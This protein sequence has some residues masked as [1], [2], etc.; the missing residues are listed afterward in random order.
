M[1]KNYFTLGHSD[2]RVSPICLG[3]MNFSLQKSDKIAPWAIDGKA[4]QDIIE[5]YVQHGGNFIDT[6]NFYTN[7]EAEKVVGKYMKDAGNRDD[8]VIA[9]KFT[10]PMKANINYM[11]NGRKN[12]MKSLEDSLERLQTNFI[13]L[14]YVHWW[15]QMSSPEEVMRSLDILVQSGKVGHIGLS[16]VPAWFFSRCQSLAMQHGYERIAAMQLEYNLVERNIEMEYFDMSRYYNT[17]I[18]PWSPIAG[19]FLTGKQTK[20]KLQGRSATGTFPVRS[21]KKWEILDCVKEVAKKIDRTPV[22]VALN[23]ALK[24]PAVSS[25][26]IGASTVEHL[27]ANMKSVEFNIPKDQ[28]KKL[29]DISKPERGAPYSFF[30]KDSFVNKMTYGD[31]LKLQQYPAWHGKDY[32][33]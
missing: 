7:G 6:A 19:G 23:W 8:L 11:G 24:R 21:E 25:I 31:H 12:M 13:D 1:K 4:P 2:L 3:T 20:E 29:N 16:D 30:D 15:D 27:N 28:L 17:A 18:I 22:E 5:S 9:T 14:F 33:E 32:Q 10:A 26:I